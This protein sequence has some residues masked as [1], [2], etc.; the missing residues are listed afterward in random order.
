VSGAGA[1]TLGD[2]EPADPPFSIAPVE[3]MLRLLVK[4]SRA[5]QLYLHNNPMHARALDLARA[6]FAALWEHTDTLV[7]EVSDTAL[8][9]AGRAV[10]AE[11]EKS[12]DSL[13]WLLHKDGVRELHFLRGFENELLAFL[14]VVQRARRTSPDEDDLLTLL[15]E[16]DFACLRYRHVDVALDDAPP[17]ESGGT[18]ERCASSWAPEAQGEAE[19]GATAAPDSGAETAA[20]PLPNR[21]VNIDDFDATLYFLDERE[22]A[23]L[24]SE[25][26]RESASDLRRNVIAIL[27]DIFESQEADSVREEICAIL[28]DLVVQLLAAGELRAVAYLLRETAAAAGRATSLTPSHRARL[29]AL[30]ERL[31]SPAAMSQLLQTLEHAA[32]R[33]PHDELVELF[34]Q[35]R[36]TALGTALGWIPRLQDPELRALLKAAADRMAASNTAE[37]VRLIGDQD[38]AVALEA[39]RRAAALRSLGAVPA[40]ARMLS[41]GDA[42]LRLAAV[43]ALSDIGSAGA[44]Q[45]LER[46]VEDADRD[47]RVGAARAIAARAYR[48]AL[49]RVESA[50]KGKRLRGADLT[51]KMA[52]FEAY[53]ALC[54]DAGVPLLDGM[55]NGRGLLGRRE[56]PELRACAARALGLV[57]TPHGLAALRAAASDKEVLVRSAVNRSLRGSGS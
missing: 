11:P 1:L 42:E 36:A 37:L 34:G 47:V 57:A 18:A 24:R 55:L 53:G 17:L 13:P 20:G 39:T 2:V 25:V 15:W 23:Y 45:A 44:L 43:A 7:L 38:R 12:S 51:E 35:L 16:R 22:V 41:E 49:A 29:A 6:S 40:L 27:L 28:D 10:L 9:W 50:V 48:P 31:S 21:I 33:P 3:E 46:A 5:H 32:A 14:D 30:P 19:A 26:A 8:T 54:G 4:A 52:F 56:D